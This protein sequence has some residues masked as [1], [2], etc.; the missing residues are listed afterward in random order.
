MRLL[1]ILTLLTFICAEEDKAT[2]RTD[3]VGDKCVIFSK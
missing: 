2:V 1:A 3:Y